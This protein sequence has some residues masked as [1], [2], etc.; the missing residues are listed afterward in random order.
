MEPIQK[1]CRLLRMTNGNLA[2]LFVEMEKI[3]GKT[4]VAEKISQENDAMVERKLQELGI[5]RDKADASFV[6]AELLKKTKEA[7]ETFFEFLGKP[8]YSS[9][10]GCSKMVELVR[11]INSG[12]SKG[13]FLSEEKLRSFLFLNPPRNILKVLGYESVEQMLAKEDLFEIFAALRFVESER[14]LNEV[15]FRPYNDVRPEN[16]EEREVKIKV[17]SP[18]WEQIG[19]KFVG[20]KLHNISHLK[21]A[22][23]IFMIPVKKENF[24]GQSLEAFSLI[25]HYL[26][27]IDFYC[28]LFKSHF[29]KPDFG[30]R[31][32]K[33][34]SG[35]MALWVVPKGTTAWRII[36]RYLA[37]MDPQ[38]P[39]L[40]E[41]HVNTETVHWLKAEKEIETLAQKNPQLKLDFWRG[42]DDFTGEIFPAGKTGEEIVSFDLVDNTISL[43]H[44]GLG[45]YLYHQ[46]EAL[47]NKIFT[48]FIGEEKL[49]NMILDN[50]EKG[51]IEFK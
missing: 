6:E 13:I 26:H 18:K 20:K 33:L 40:F 41:P 12:N 34:L 35:E 5:S 2:N 43:T 51:F 24:A 3:T 4:G 30:N 19:E 47:W 16:F 1:I 14:W 44:G 27:E 48:E 37:K 8:D 45:K 32:A 21:E 50:I 46:Q 23:L 22:G 28:Q 38:D 29:D 11:S 49:E 10:T 39:R 7:D 9:E 15:F 42:A 31:F 36:Q 17:L 25:L